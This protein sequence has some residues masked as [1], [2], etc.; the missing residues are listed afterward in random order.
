LPNECYYG[1][2]GEALADGSLRWLSPERLCQSL[3]NTEADAHSH[4]LDWAQ[5][6][7]QKRCR[8]DWRNWGDFQSC[9]GG[10]VKVSTEETFWSSRGLD[11]Q[12]KSTHG[13]THGSGHRIGRGW[14]TSVRG[15]S[16]GSEDI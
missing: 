2:W 13:G 3:T 4:L 7:W 1:C 8:R 5:D 9:G 12:S 14:Y 10:G 11:Y 15:M 16:L 6:P